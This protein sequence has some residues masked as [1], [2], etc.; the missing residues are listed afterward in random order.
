MQKKIQ[1]SLKPA[2]VTK[3]FER[4][5]EYEKTFLEQPSIR[6]FSTQPNLDSHINA[7]ICVRQQIR[8]QTV[9]Q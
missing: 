4:R 8:I 1:K 7:Q 6:N 2:K 5:K 3:N 9:N